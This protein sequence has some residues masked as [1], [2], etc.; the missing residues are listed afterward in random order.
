[1]VV[2]SGAGAM[3]SEDAEG[4]AGAGE[5]RGE[6]PEVNDLFPSTYTLTYS[7]SESFVNVNGTFEY[8]KIF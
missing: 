7:I 3:C 5:T 2:T 6:C 8:R 1:M 4:V